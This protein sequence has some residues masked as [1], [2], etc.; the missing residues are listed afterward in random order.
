MTALVGDNFNFYGSAANGGGLTLMGQGIWTGPLAGSGG[1]P[2]PTVPPFET[3]GKSWFFCDSNGGST[4]RRIFPT[5]A[6]AAVGAVFRAR[7]VTL[8]NTVDDSHWRIRDGANLQVMNLQVMPDGNLRVL[9]AAG[10]VVTTTTVP[11]IQVGVAHKIQYQ[12]TFHATL[13]AIE[14]RVDNV[15]VIGGTS[16]VNGANLSLAGTA[17][18]IEFS[19]DAGGGTRDFWVDFVFVYSLT[20]TYNANWPNV[21]GA[22]YLQLTGNPV[23][24]FTPRPRQKF[25]AG[26]LLNPGTGS[27]LD[28]STSANFNLGSGDFTIETLYRP[29]A[30]EVTTD[31][32]TLFGKW[33]RAT[34]NRSYRLVRY[35]P[36]VNGG[37]LRWE[38]STDGLTGTVVAINSIVYPFVIGHW[39][40]IAVSRTAGVT[41]IFIDGVQVGLAIADGN[42]YFASGTNSKFVVGGEMSD[43]V[44]TVLAG[45]SVNGRFDEFRATVGV[46]RYTS[47]YTPAVAAFPRTIG[48]DPS[49]ASVQLLWGLDNSVIDESTTA[50]KTL[51]ARGSAAREVNADAAASYLVAN[52]LTPDDTRYLEAAFLR[53]TNILQFTG[54]P[55]NTQTVTVGATV[56]TFNTVLGAANSILI[57]AT[58]ADSMQN[59]VDAINLGPGI[60]TRYGTGT[61]VNL[62]ATAA[63]GPSAGSDITMSAILAGTAGNSIVSTETVANAS[64]LSGATFAGGSNIPGFSEYTVSPL[65]PTATGLRALFLI[66]RSFIDADSATLRKSLNVSGSVAAGADN[67]LTTSP[68]YRMD[69]IEQDPSTGV[70]L[71][72]VSVVN[73]RIRLLRTS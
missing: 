55:A 23:D 14:V 70:G 29:S 38:I 16:G 43:N 1:T 6:V 46:G 72:P 7:Y 28:C 19:N 48:G 71:T 58:T 63:I 53:A 12:A 13:G 39:Y 42:T 31:E 50:V 20:G 61:T 54:Q 37:A 60:G 21:S 36:S 40:A 34:N 33:L 32:H 22:A 57:G 62:S 15:P 49:F 9:N 18:S 45:S 41:R 47:N 30:Q 5:G 52:Q 11:C 51:T 67:A 59:L 10:A 68:A 26:V 8:P 69:V 73:G 4:G 25:G 66:D 27:V 24:T 35:G 56:Y 65:P 2:N 3:T 17:A 44:N 64:F